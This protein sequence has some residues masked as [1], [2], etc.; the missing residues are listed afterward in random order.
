MQDKKYSVERIEE[1]KKKD[2]KEL[3][4]EERRIANLNPVKKGEVRNPNGRPKGAKNWSTHFRRLMGDEKLLKSVISQLPKQWDGIVD[5]IPADVIA[6]GLITSVTQG[7][8][9]AVAEGK[10]I[11]K[12][13]LDMIDRIQRI[14]YGETK[15]VNLDTQEE[16][17]FEKV[18]F[19]FITKEDRPQPEE[20]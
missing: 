15:N 5:E 4:P 6:A 11:D 2:L 7:I 16:G 17:F 10:P 13:T 8:A 9:K 14:G 18:N 12:N 19:N 1:L 3:T 20:S